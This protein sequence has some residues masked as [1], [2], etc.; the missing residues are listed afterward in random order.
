VG[1][2]MLRAAMAAPAMPQRQTARRVRGYLAA[3]VV[4]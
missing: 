1:G 4:C 2:G 3:A